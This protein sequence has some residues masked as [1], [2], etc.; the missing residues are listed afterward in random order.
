[1]GTFVIEWFQQPDILTYDKMDFIPP[2]LK[3]PKYVYNSF[4]GIAI[5]ELKQKKFKKSSFDVILNHI[6]VM[7]NYDKKGY[8]YML[9]YLAHMFQKLG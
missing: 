4:T 5:D 9:D 8:E 6:K 1:M 2:P 3:C 7:V